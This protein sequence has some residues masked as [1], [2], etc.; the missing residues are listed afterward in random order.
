MI[1]ET[2]YKAWEYL[3]TFIR[4]KIHDLSNTVIVW[5]LKW[6]LPVTYQVSQDLNIPSTFVV[7]K[8]LIYNNTTF[9]VITQWWIKLYN[10]S[11][12]AKLWLSEYD[13]KDIEKQTYDECKYEKEKYWLF[14]NDFQWKQVIVIDDWIY[15]WF[16]AVAVA[17]Q[18]KE[19]WA[20]R[21]ILAIPVSNNQILS[22]LQ[23]FYDEIVCVEPIEDRNFALSKYYMSYYKLIW[24]DVNELFYK[25]KEKELFLQ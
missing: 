15:S 21:L 13:V 9:W 18:L 8:K 14:Y 16:S 20:S 7:A 2:R 11:I 3:S 25:M 10:K 22:K 19:Q 5:I 17:K 24:E 23:T 4:N 12:I 1:F 6:W